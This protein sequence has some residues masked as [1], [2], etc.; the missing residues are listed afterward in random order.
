MVEF[1]TSA[2]ARITEDTA[3]QLKYYSDC[4]QGAFVAG[5]LWRDVLSDE[6][7]LKLTNDFGAAIRQWGGAVEIYRHVN[8]RVSRERAIIEVAHE[9]GM[10]QAPQHARLVRA[11][12]ENLEVAPQFGARP[13]WNGVTLTFQ[14][15][16]IREVRAARASNIAVILDAFE[17]LAWPERID[18][19]DVPDLSPWKV[20]QTVYDLN[21][22][23]KVIFFRVSRGI[24][25]RRR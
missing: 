4:T 14:G 16:T 17:S 7:R 19:S 5:R 15:E 23:L 6:D 24:L 18:L 12:G 21:R 10:M 22:G 11:I 25:W 9:L 13:H 1:A 3:R 2:G 8:S 20:H